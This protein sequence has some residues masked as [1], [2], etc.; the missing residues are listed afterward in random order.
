MED[1]RF[2]EK[3]Q[4]FKGAKMKKAILTLGVSVLSLFAFH[5]EAQSP[6][7]CYC[8]D[9]VCPPD[10]QGLQDSMESQG[11]STFGQAYS[12]KNQLAIPPTGPILF[13][14]VV[15]ASPSI[16]F[17]FASTTGEIVIN[18]SGI[19]S[20]DFTFHGQLTPP[21]PAPPVPA[22]SISLFQNGSPVLGSTFGNFTL[23]PDDTMTHTGGPT[24]VTIAAGDAIQVVNTSTLPVDKFSVVPGP[25]LP[26]SGAT[27][28][29]M[30][31]QPL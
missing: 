15:F 14:N 1:H 22:W 8:A 16:D 30:L 13:E 26:V 24:L 31:L 17:S 18:K 5:L 4:K 7:G 25:T 20:I 23:T 21:L 27:I 2:F 10:L 3:E 12:I 6:A 19:Y 28:L 29:I 11:T 9:C